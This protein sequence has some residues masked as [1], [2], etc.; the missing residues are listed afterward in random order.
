MSDATAPLMKAPQT[1]EQRIKKAI[2]R[3]DLIS[4]VRALHR[5]NYDLHDIVFRSVPHQGAS[6]TLI[7]D[8]EFHRKPTRYVTVY[9]TMGLHDD[10]G[11][12]PSYFMRVAD[13]MED[14]GPLLNFLAYFDSR[15]LHNHINTLYVELG[16]NIYDSWSDLKDA[17]GT[18]TSLNSISGLHWLFSLYY[19]ELRIAVSRTEAGTKRVNRGATTGTARLDG[20]AIMGKT[21]QGLSKGFVVRIYAH[22]EHHMSGESWPN[23]AQRRLLEHIIPRLRGLSFWLKVKLIVLEHQTPTSISNQ[24]YLGFSRLRATERARLELS[25]YDKLCI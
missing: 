5:A 19:P 21:A 16:Q 24:E 6:R 20:T 10:R 17:Y 25:L 23:L 18:M 22:E 13:Q 9:L 11:L 8:I 2:H 4:L 7:R 15:L 1:L 14:P 12:L 3:F